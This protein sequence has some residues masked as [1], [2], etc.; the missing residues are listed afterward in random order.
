MIE[1][2]KVQCPNCGQWHR[3]DK[4]QTFHYPNL[5]GFK[6]EIWWQCGGC[7]ASHKLVD[8][9]RKTRRKFTHC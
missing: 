9:K 1:V 5:L 7:L 4:L 8:C 2:V 3:L 6:N